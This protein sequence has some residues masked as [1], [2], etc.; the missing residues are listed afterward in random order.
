VSLACVRSHYV[1]R[2]DDGRVT[3]NIEATQAGYS[4]FKSDPDE[5]L[6]EQYELPAK[7]ISSGSDLRAVT[8]RELL[9]I[10]VGCRARHMWD[11][12]R[13]DEAERDFLLARYL[14]PSNRK[15]YSGATEV[16][17]QRSVRLFEPGE[18]GSPQ[19]LADWL[20]AKYRVPHP[21]GWERPTNSSIKK[22]VRISK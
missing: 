14:F 5:Y 11:T 19:S 22:V 9:G 13:L 18:V 10:F 21:S 7:A 4:G 1:C 17:V 16:T 8:P 12:D 3:Y 15:L 6:I 20:H 2:Y